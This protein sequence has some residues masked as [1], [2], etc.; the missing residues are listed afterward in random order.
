MGTPFSV[1][2]STSNPTEANPAV[3]D[4]VTVKS[5]LTKTDMDAL[6]NSPLPTLT[7]KAYAVQYENIFDSN[8]TPNEN[9]VIAW[10][11]A[12]TTAQ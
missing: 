10:N 11:E 5:D 12:K 8:K 6:D 4:K 1:I 3:N 2:T 7:F 9:A